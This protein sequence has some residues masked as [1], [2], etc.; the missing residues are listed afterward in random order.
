[1]KLY[2]EMSIL[3]LQQARSMIEM[4]LASRLLG[5]PRVGVSPHVARPMCNC[6]VHRQ[7]QST[8]GWQCPV[9]GQQW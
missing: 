9:H 6:A 7:G 4:E 1:V 2:S 5:D 8:G 3:E